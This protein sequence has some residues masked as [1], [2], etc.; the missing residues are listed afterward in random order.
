M[1]PAPVA[2]AVAHRMHGMG[3][4]LS[5]QWRSGSIR[6][7]AMA[8]ML[9]ILATAAAADTGLQRTGDL[10]E[11]AETETLL[12]GATGIYCVTTPCP[13]TG[14]QRID[15]DGAPRLLWSGDELPEITASDA[16]T[17]Q[18]RTAWDAGDCLAITGSFDDGHLVVQSID[19]PC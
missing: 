11:A 17:Q 14:V 16:D 3:H 12:V 5:E 9:A 6:S 2:A 10:P 8:A 7:G 19:S 1:L 15:A 13:W 4:G 18:L